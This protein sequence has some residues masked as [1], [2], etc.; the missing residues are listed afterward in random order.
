MVYSAIFAVQVH[1]IAVQGALGTP[2]VDELEMAT[3][4]AGI[5]ACAVQ[6]THTM[7]HHSTHTI[8]HVATIRVV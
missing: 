6:C 7:V 3:I 2:M 5:Q 4:R 8:A 1:C